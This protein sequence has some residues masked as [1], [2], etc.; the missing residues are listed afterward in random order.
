MNSSTYLG[1]VSYKPGLGSLRPAQ[2]AVL[3]HNVSLMAIQRL[4]AH[5]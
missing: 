1:L 3:P 4:M 2:S 5:Q